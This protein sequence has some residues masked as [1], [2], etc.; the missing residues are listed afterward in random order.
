MR[1]LA[2]GA[3]ADIARAQC[4][5]IRAQL[6]V[7]LWPTG[8]LVAASTGAAAEPDP[9]GAALLARRMGRAVHRAATYGLFRPKCLTRALALKKLLE[10]RGVRSA[11]LCVGVRPDGS[12]LLA[13]AWVEH[14]EAVL[15]DRPAHVH[16][17]SR[18]AEL[19][20]MASP[21]DRGE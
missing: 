8:R 6:A 17:F 15:A 3:Y 13:H 18:L 2:A 20:L 7:W 4:A 14:G 1:R 16:S 5:L 10:D 12:R 9:P 19:D 11:R 21:G